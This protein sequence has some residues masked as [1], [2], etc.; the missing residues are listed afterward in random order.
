MIRFRKTMTS[1]LK[2]FIH[3]RE[4]GRYRPAI[5]WRLLHHPPK[6]SVSQCRRHLLRRSGDPRESL[7]PLT[8]GGLKWSS[9]HF[10]LDG[11]DGGWRWTEELFEVSMRW[12]KRGCGTV[13]GGG[14]G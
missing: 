9:Q 10:I 3:R 7:C 2:T 5:L 4:S 8:E 1:R 11:R 13:G 6:P 12:R 14:G